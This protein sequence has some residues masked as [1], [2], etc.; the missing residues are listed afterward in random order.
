V[1]FA[2]ALP[3]VWSLRIDWRFF[4]E[5]LGRSPPQALRDLAVHRAVEWI[6]VVAYFLGIA[7]WYQVLPA[8]AA[9]VEL[10]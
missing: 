8:W 9:K 3:L 5:T 7:L 2:G 4:R 1:L 6:G 10:R